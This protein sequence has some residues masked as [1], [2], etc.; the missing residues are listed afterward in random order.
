MA[1]FTIKHVE[2]NVRYFAV[3]AADE[4]E[5]YERFEDWRDNG[6][7]VYNAMRDNWDIECESFVVNYKV[8]LDEEDILTDEKYKAL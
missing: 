3:E 8:R 4:Y 5:A 6:E 7:Y 2:T 1:L